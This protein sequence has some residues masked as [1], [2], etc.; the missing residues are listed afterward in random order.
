MPSHLIFPINESSQVGE[1]RRMASRIAE[2]AGFGENDR[3]KV[4]IVAT[5][6]AT[7]LV[8]HARQGRILLR[9]FRSAAES[10]VEIL[11]IDSNPG[12]ADFA[13]C[14]ADGYSTAGTP[15][16]GL[17]AVK[18]LSRTF[19]FYSGPGNGTVILSQIA[20]GEF[21]DTQPSRSHFEWCAL[22]VAAPG[23]TVCGD[24]CGVEVREGQLRLM[25]AD[26]LGH[27]PG[28]AEASEK[29]CDVFTQMNSF[30]P[31]ALIELSHRSLMGTRGAALAAASADANSQDLEFAG[32]GNISASL[33]SLT[34]SRGLMS[35]NGTLGAQFRSV[36]QLTYQWAKDSILVLHSDG[37]KTHWSLTDNPGLFH[38]HPAVIAAVL[39]RD[40]CR[41]RDD[42]SI[43]VVR[44]KSA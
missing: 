1:A 17:G 6:L 41:G 12:K 16:N 23:E 10:I 43:V 42:A 4:A 44:R 29:A 27:G 36:R 21:K 24:A 26:G 2:Q 34:G 20:P 31:R 13:A 11:S 25:I 5:E 14:L 3:G 33:Q 18:R 38:C 32:V 8:K 39:L 37:I 40:Q 22:T 30:T 7:N 9:S 15:G 19:D 35:Y 28:A